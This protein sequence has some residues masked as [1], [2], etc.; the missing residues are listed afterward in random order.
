MAVVLVPWRGG[1][2]HREAAWGW[3]SR[4]YAEHHP[5]WR[6]VRC[7]CPSGPWVKAAAVM[8]VVAECS[9]EVLVI[10]DADVWC[11]GVAEATEAVQQG[12][13]WAIPHRHVARLAPKATAAVLDGAEPKGQ[14]L[15][16]A[17]YRGAPGGGIVVAHRDT[18]LDIP[19]DPRFAGW[20]H[21][22][23]SWGA[24]LTKLAGRPWRGQL[25]LH[26]LWH[27]P[28]PEQS[29]DRLLG[30]AENRAL[31]SRYL[32]AAKDATRMTE[33]IEEARIWR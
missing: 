15:E 13:P 26:H 28:Q 21:E 7:E 25:V 22:D 11:E 2:P 12:A 19:L 32:R 17:P 1:C 3:V 16:Q 20:G 30:T 5:D 9:E 6:V 18:L 8:P 29:A 10:A 4:R 14:P 31:Y 27:P 33:L 24:A 23:A